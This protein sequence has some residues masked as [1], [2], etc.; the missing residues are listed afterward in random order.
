LAQTDSSIKVSPNFDT[1][2]TSSKY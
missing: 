2:L 1:F